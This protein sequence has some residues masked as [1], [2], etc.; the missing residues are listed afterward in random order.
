MQQAAINK[1]KDWLDARESG[2]WLIIFDNGDDVFES[3]LDSEDDRGTPLLKQIVKLL[4]NRGCSVITTRDKRTLRSRAAKVGIELGVV[5]EDDAKTLF[6]ERWMGPDHFKSPR[7]E[8]LVGNIVVKLGFLPLAIDQAAAYVHETKISLDEYIARI[9]AQPDQRLQQSSVDAD[10]YSAS[11]AKTWEL[12]VSFIDSKF[13]VAG[14]LFRLL[15][16]FDNESMSE[17][18]IST[19]LFRHAQ[20]GDS[21]RP[22]FSDPPEKVKEKLRDLDDE[23]HYRS[24]L[25]ALD[26]LSLARRNA[27]GKTIWVHELVHQWMRFRMTKLDR[28]FWSVAAVETIGHAGDFGV[29]PKSG[30]TDPTFHLFIEVASC[31]NDIRDDAMKIFSH[32]TTNVLLEAPDCFI[33]AKKVKQAIL[34]MLETFIPEGDDAECGNLLALSVVKIVYQSDHISNASDKYTDVWTD[35][36]DLLYRAAVFLD[37]NSPALSCRMVEQFHETFQLQD[38]EEESLKVLLTLLASLRVQT[39]QNASQPLKAISG[40]FHAVIGRI[41]MEEGEHRKAALI[42]RSAIRLLQ[43]AG[44]TAETSPYLEE[45]TTHLAD[46]LSV[47]GRPQS[48]LLASQV[49]ANKFQNV[50]AL[51][52]AFEAEGKRAQAE[53]LYAR[54]CL[55]AANVIRKFMAPKTTYDS[56]GYGDAGGKL[57]ASFASHGQSDI[58]AALFSYRLMDYELDV[59]AWARRDPSAPVPPGRV[60]SWKSWTETVEALCGCLEDGVVASTDNL[61]ICRERARELYNK[62]STASS[63]GYWVGL[64]DVVAREE[65]MSPLAGARRIIHDQFPLAVIDERVQKLVDEVEKWLQNIDG[66]REEEDAEFYLELEAEM[67]EDESF[68]LVEETKGDDVAKVQAL[69]RLRDVSQ[70]LTEALQ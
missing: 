37:W 39:L 30:S 8:I 38:M 19:G 63:R 53:G 35:A 47:L 14:Q 5:S 25:D 54:N 4:P 32:R 20:P 52:R 55:H 69:Q 59:A 50:E 58:A 18:F 62:V 6:F 21:L 13:P 42:L 10:Q 56:T 3:P 49:Q 7:E 27:E 15:A 36:L 28:F 66:V 70:Q 40:E 67:M 24:A 51:I 1:A 45:S 16:F 22:R 65:V 2:K 61:S 33:S 11:V 44:M 12:S 26:A 48:Q 60:L 29:F 9:D 68:R 17:S 64:E 34:R 43:E 57:A 23:E 41:L 31:I 46:C